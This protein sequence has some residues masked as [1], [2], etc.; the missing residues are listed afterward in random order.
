MKL[1]QSFLIAL[2][3]II[4]ALTSWELYWRSQGKYPN[5]NDD[6]ALWAMHRANVETASKDDVIIFGSSRAYFDIQIDEWEKATGKKPI[7]LASP[8]SSPLPSFH[9]LVNNTSFNG[10]VILGVTPGLF[11]STTYPG[12]DPWSRIQTKVDHFYNR[13]Y[14][15]RSNFWLSI[16]L[17]T[18][19]V[20]MSADEELWSDDIDLKSL[21]RRVKIGDRTGNPQMPP[22]YSFGDVRLDRNMSMTKRTVQDTA[23]ANSIIKV[24]SYLG[25]SAPPPDKKSTMAFF[26]EDLKKFKER[27]GKLI[28]LR[29]PSSGG[30]RMGENMVFPRVDFWD[31][32]VEQSDVPSYHFEDYDQ[33]KD[34]TCPEESHLSKEDAEYFTRELAKIIIEDGIIIN[35]KTK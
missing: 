35:S 13:T 29:C 21:L 27:N 7:Q 28:L 14:A 31:D 4:I 5:L 17:Q 15:D 20:L 34:L 16:P 10:T 23:F 11:F 6:K 18:N 30:N 22:F 32:L 8:G 9:D 3:L 24:W 19:L 26:L 2:T 25:K 12:A 1:K 33:L